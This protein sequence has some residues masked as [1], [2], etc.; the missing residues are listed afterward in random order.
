MRRLCAL[1][2]LVLLG[3]APAPGTLRG[4]LPDAGVVW[5]SDGR[6]LPQQRGIEIT[7]H[8]KAF[9][10][11]LAVVSSGSVVQFRN[12]D[13]VD[14]SVYSISP[15]GPFDLGIYE[16]GP[17]KDVRFERAGVIEVRCHIHRMM[18][19]TLIVVDGPYAALASAGAWALTG[20]RPGRHLLHAWTAREGERTQMVLV[21]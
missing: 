1:F 19:A 7:Q 2:A 6:R 5:I 16:A 17:G 18:H 10:P 12:D 9:V 13:T 15:A 21:R 4:T 14:H 11:A 8:D 20:V 3:T